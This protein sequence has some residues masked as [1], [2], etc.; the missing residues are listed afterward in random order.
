MQ[1]DQVFTGVASK[2][3]RIAGNAL[4]LYVFS[5]RSDRLVSSLFIVVLA[6]VDLTTCLLVIPVTAYL[7]YVSLNISNDFLCK[8]YYFFLCTTIL[9]STFVMVAIAVDRYFC[10]CHPWRQAV[11]KLRAKILLAV[12]AIFSS[13]HGCA[14]ACMNGVYHDDPDLENF[15]NHLK[16]TNCSDSATR[17]QLLNETLFQR[18]DFATLA[19]I[20][21]IREGTN[22]LILVISSE[23]CGDSFNL[24]GPTV[25]FVYKRIMFAIFG[26]SVLAVFIL[27]IAIYRSV[28]ARRVRRMRNRRLGTQPTLIVA[29]PKQ[30][31][32][33]VPGDESNTQSDKFGVGKVTNVSSSS[34]TTSRNGP[35][36][37]NLIYKLRNRK[38]HE[39]LTKK[40]RYNSETIY[41]KLL[42]ANRNYCPCPSRNLADNN[43]SELKEKAS[44]D[45]GANSHATILTLNCISATNKT[46]NLTAKNRPKN[47]IDDEIEID[48]NYKSVGDKKQ[49]NAEP[50]NRNAA[51]GRCND[52]DNNIRKSRTFDGVPYEKSTNNNITH[53]NK[54]NNNVNFNSNNNNNVIFNNNNDNNTVNFNNNNNNN[55]NINNNNNDNNTVNFNNNNNNN[56]NFDNKINNDVNPNSTTNDKVISSNTSNSLTDVT[57]CKH[58]DVISSSDENIAITSI[59][60]RNYHKK[61]KTLNHEVCQTTSPNQLKSLTTVTTKPITIVVSNHACNNE[62]V[63]NNDSNNTTSTA[64][65]NTNKIILNNNICNRPSLAT[66]T[67][68]AATTQATKPT[69]LE[70]H[71]SENMKIAFML[72]IVTVVFVLSFLP[73]ILILLQILPFQ[74][75]LFYVYFINNLSNPVIYSFLNVNFRNKLKQ[76][77]CF[78]KKQNIAKK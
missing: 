49:L 12:L 69:S 20:P 38:H 74:P 43:V 3:G 15:Q 60:P 47:K 14:I 9:Y 39:P 37:S 2:S 5:C 32:S 58:V 18:P 26:L 44:A 62:N 24:I 8:F 57:T 16:V 73:A 59:R 71:V 42:D 45:D 29:F 63:C 53:Y 17:E 67:A 72:F 76:L 23:L 55:V 66:T 75:F 65:A 7:E 6:V 19:C 21:K 40:R 46:S 10:L 35:F 22:Q 31:I 51:D 34:V 36:K 61:E 25:Q 78:K 52:G 4:V 27:Y 30:S 1:T 33:V 64:V 56:V 28:T 68:A 48:D 54:N 41:E 50:A 77:L 13:V 70:I 11:T